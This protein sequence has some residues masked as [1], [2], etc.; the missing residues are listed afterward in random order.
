MLVV[1]SKLFEWAVFHNAVVMLRRVGRSHEVGCLDKY[2]ST[3][4]VIKLFDRLVSLFLIPRKNCSVQRLAA[5][6]SKTMALPLVFYMN[7]FVGIF[8]SGFFS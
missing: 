4:K 5:I 8:E 2:Y 6:L 3:R 7:I 1:V